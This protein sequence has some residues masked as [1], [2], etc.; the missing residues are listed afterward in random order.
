MPVSHS[1]TGAVPLI[2]PCWG[3]T[4]NMCSIGAALSMISAEGMRNGGGTGACSSGKFRK[5]R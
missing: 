2:F 4:V 1:S 5:F 3:L